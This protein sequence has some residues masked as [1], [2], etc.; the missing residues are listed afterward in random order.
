MTA[1]YS[2]RTVG[3]TA[4]AT[5]M[6]PSAAAAVEAM[7]KKAVLA[8]MPP[9]RWC[10]RSAARAIRSSAARGWAFNGLRSTVER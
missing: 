10:L 5:T 9:M 7:L 3:P 6:P 8:I 2:P 1:A 4:L